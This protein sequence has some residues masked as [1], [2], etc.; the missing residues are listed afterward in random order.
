MSDISENSPYYRLDGA[1]SEA[2]L[3]WWKSLDDNRGVRARLRRAEVP[4]DVMLSQEFFNFL[5]RMPESWSKDYHLSASAMVAALLSHVK[6]H[7]TNHPFAAQLGLGDPSVM[8]ELRF[9]QMIKS[10]TPDEI[11]IRLLRAVRILKGKVNILS[12]VEG[13][14]LWHKE[15]S[16]GEDQNPMRR[17]S[18]KWAHDYYLPKESRL[19]KQPETS[20]E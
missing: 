3:S 17:L 18:V 1:N 13:V 6:E 2:I 20:M 16:F 8:H 15:Y 11:Y 19:T 7:S 9:K 10:R 4:S 14:L 12:L 5:K